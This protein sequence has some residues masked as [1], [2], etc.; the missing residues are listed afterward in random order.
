MRARLLLVLSVFLVTFHG[1]KPQRPKGILSDS[2]MKDILVDYH[3]AQ[4]MAENVDE[5][6]KVACYKYVQTVFAKHGVTE[7][8]FDSSLVYYSRYSEK[9]SEV[10]K[11]VVARIETEAERN[12][13][14]TEKVSD[15]LFANLSADGDTA[16]VW[17]GQ[18]DVTLIPDNMNHLFRFSQK[19]DSTYR[20]GDTFIWHF[21]TMS[22]VSNFLM[23][24]YALI[25]LEYAD[26]ST[27]HMSKSFSGNGTVDLRLTEY[28]VTDSVPVRRIRGFIYMPPKKTDKGEFCLLLVRDLSL[29]RMH[30]QVE[31]KKDTVQTDT[32]TA[33]SV[34]TDSVENDA[35]RRVRLTPEQLRDRQPHDQR[36]NVTKEKPLRVKSN[37]NRLR[38]K[39]E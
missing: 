17:A 32:L 22:V 29:I 14:V 26:D 21:N 5:N 9:M 27:V 1:C 11:S 13:I 33:D 24:A 19:T 2:K 36:I 37:N 34:M 18:R 39:Q 12:G 20:A 16:D 30:K 28:I 25:Q 38:R 23:E 8:E 7:A 4:G 6:H 31:E 15:N 35:T 3:L 10:C